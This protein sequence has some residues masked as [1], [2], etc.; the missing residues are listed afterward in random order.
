MLSPHR[1]KVLGKGFFFI[2]QAAITKLRQ[3]LGPERNGLG[4]FTMDRILVRLITEQ[5]TK[6]DI[7][8]IT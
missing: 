1:T 8:M 4:Q 6:L 2:K 3:E 7:K 5:A